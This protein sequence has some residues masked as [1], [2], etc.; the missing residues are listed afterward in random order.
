MYENE[1]FIENIINH[2]HVN[3]KFENWPLT[4]IAHQKYKYLQFRI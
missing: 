2:S 1:L 4:W 3:T